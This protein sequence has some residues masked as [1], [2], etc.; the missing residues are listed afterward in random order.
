[1]RNLKIGKLIKSPVLFH[2]SVKERKNKKKLHKKIKN[3]PEVKIERIVSVSSEDPI[4]KAENLLKKLKWRCQNNGEQQV[5]VV[6]QLNKSVQI[7]LLIE[8]LELFLDFS[9]FPNKHGALIT[10]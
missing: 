2:F 9:C 3:M 6:L 10:V 8:K 7:R 1:M 5:S 4:F